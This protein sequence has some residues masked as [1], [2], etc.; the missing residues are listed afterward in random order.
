[1]LW[2]IRIIGLGI[3]V[4]ILSMIIA[5]AFFRNGTEKDVTLVYVAIMDFIVIAVVAKAFLKREK[6][7]S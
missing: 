7:S 1:M 4:G 5:A 6:K 3:L 2:V